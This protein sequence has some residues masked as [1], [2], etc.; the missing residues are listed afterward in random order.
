MVDSPFL[1]WF[2]RVLVFSALVAS[3]LGTV[4]AA[5]PP[6]I[7]LITLDTTR[8]DRMGFLGA[9]RGLTPN[10]DALA[11]QGVVF[12]RAY[13][14]V[15]LTTASHATILSG[16][17]PQFN[18]VNDFGKPLPPGVPYLP[19]LLHKGGYRTAAF[20]GSLVLD[21]IGGT[22]P[23]FDRGFDVFDAGFHMR[24]ASEDRY[25]TVERRAETV[26][27]H[28]LRWLEKNGHGPFFLWVHLYDAHDPYDPPEPF[29]TRY[30]S[31]PYDGE[32][33]YVDFAVG[34]LLSALRAYALYDNALIAVMADHGEGLGEHG[35]NT[36]GIF[37]YDE[38]IRVPLLFKL[39]G[40]RSAGKRVATRVGLV[41]ITPTILRSAGTNV[42]VAIQGKSLLA[43]MEPRPG[44][45]HAKT[46]Q[47]EIAV[48]SD[49]PAYA[50]TDYSRR[51]FGW[52]FL[53]SIRS[54]KYLFIQAPRPELYDQSTDPQAS[55]NLAMSA[56]AV[57]QTLTSQ[58]NEFRRKTSGNL[59]SA[60]A[61]IDPQQAEKLNALG[62]VAS[63]SSSAD[64][65][66]QDGGT[67]PKDKIEIANFMHDALLDVENGRYREAVP[68]LERTVAQQPQMPIAQMQ[69]GIAL[70]RLKD[71]AK[72]IPPLQKTVELLPDSGMGHYE[73]GLALFET[74][75]R[76]AAAPQ[77]EAAV[78]RAPR[79]ADAHF[80]L[81]S[82]YARI[83]RVPDA[84]QELNTALKLN[85]D[86]YRA[87]LLRGRILS[88][89][90]DASAALANLQKAVQ[91]EPNSREAHLF[92]GDAYAQLGQ[93]ENARQ[94][95]AE[96]QRLAPTGH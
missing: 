22:A 92:L 84:M 72:A 35:E 38:T 75:D 29:A 37:L 78:A 31:E 89:Q 16:T 83:A 88:L 47:N 71:F 65:K 27:A 68:L 53:R 87:N 56:T 62:Y 10:L 44:G 52:S 40:A 14:H 36:H 51:A 4:A 23:G 45:A 74:G 77:F 69:L 1:M 3:P 96:A 15:P 95:R 85:P 63:D 25:Q 76:K 48:D 6:N 90:G 54:G 70:A 24:R 5:I 19:E 43:L 93:E 61:A 79:W 82:V 59:N 91:I 60:Q 50:E 46:I 9:A 67:D 80:S 41:D 2:R 81:A 30:K 57:T 34:K 32:I 64:T 73:L 39:P 28:A 18:H 12:T 13:A 21:P 11:K 49:R 94:Q 33:A 58:L 17:Y 26:V 42:P 7:V 20:V 55:R 8:A 86:H 66:V